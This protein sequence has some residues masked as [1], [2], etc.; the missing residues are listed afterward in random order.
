MM[1]PGLDDHRAI[2]EA[3]VPMLAESRFRVKSRVVEAATA[4]IFFSIKDGD[5]MPGLTPP[6]LDVTNTYHRSLEGQFSNPHNITSKG[7][8]QL[9][10]GSMVGESEADRLPAIYRMIEEEKNIRNGIPILLFTP[11]GAWNG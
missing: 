10:M 5:I 4:G 3:L 9:W 7:F 2:G 11:P 1:I 6:V 8:A